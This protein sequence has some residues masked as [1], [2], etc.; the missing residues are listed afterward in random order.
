MRAGLARSHTALF[1]STWLICAAAA[2]AL[3]GK[4]HPGLL[5]GPDVGEPSPHRSL[6]ERDEGGRVR[7][8]PMPPAIA[9]VGLL[10]LEA[11]AQE[12]IEALL[13][14]RA[15]LIDGLLEANGD[16]VEA[17]RE[18]ISAGPLGERWEELRD[19]IRGMDAVRKWGRVDRRVAA[20]LPS[21]KRGR[22]RDAIA[23]YERELA[24]TSEGGPAGT[25]RLVRYWE[26]LAWELDRALA[27]RDAARGEKA[28]PDRL[29]E[30]LGLDEEQAREIRRMADKFDR[31][32]GARPSAHEARALVARLRTVMDDGQRWA[33]T[34][35][36]LRGEFE[37]LALAPAAEG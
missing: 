33:F 31:E 12:E 25:N 1:L 16:R 27:R 37:P 13:A 15:E 18:L 29:I 3:P 4:A 26:N 8:L 6:I 17:I 21:E 11:D 5:A 35:L 23:S 36:I 28:W 20:R 24:K 30:S 10:D 9:A 2:I 22:Y 19:A 32:T 34:R 14:E 7:A